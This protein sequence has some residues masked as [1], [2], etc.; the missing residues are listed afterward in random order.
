MIML[1]VDKM[2]AMP[3]ATQSKTASEPVRPALEIAT[4]L[5]R[6]MS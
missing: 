2:A 4:R 1:P 5:P 6:I 3:K